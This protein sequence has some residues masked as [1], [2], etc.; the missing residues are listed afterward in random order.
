M[1]LADQ[2]AAIEGD[3]VRG[4]FTELEAARDFAQAM[5]ALNYVTMITVENG[6]WIVTAIAQQ[7]LAGNAES[8]TRI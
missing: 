4:P 1:R 8:I 7:G 3:M 6:L 2:H 5:R